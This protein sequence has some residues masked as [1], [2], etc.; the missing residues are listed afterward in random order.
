MANHEFLMILGIFL[1]IW[2]FFGILFILWDLKLRKTYK[3]HSIEYDK[4]LNPNYAKL[5]SYNGKTPTKGEQFI[6]VS[7]D[8]WVIVKWDKEFKYLKIVTP[9]P[10][11]LRP[12]IGH[13]SYNAKFKEVQKVDIKDLARIH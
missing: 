6:I 12:N 13:L 1:F 10:H 9:P 8:I 3:K 2:L 7:E 11:E 4:T 5:F